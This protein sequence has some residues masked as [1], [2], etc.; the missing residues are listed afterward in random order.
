[1]NDLVK[2]TKLKPVCLGAARF[3]AVWPRDVQT[4]SP[5]EPARRAAQVMAK[6]NVGSIPAVDGAKLVGTITER[7]VK[8]RFSAAGKSPESSR[9]GDVMSIDKALDAISRP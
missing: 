8:V 5:E 7:G 4:I 9:V 2:Y 6:L 1:M 3:D